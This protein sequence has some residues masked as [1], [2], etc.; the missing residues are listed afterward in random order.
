MVEGTPL[1]RV[2][3]VNSGAR[4]QIP[5][6]PLQGR[7]LACT[8]ISKQQCNP[9]DSREKALRQPD[10]RDFREQIPKQNSKSQIN[11]IVD[12]AGTNLNNFIESLILAQD[13]RWRRA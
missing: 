1:E 6:S 5:P 2:Q 8:L 13:E 12:P 7:G 4:V 11:N 3:V 10:L 9:E